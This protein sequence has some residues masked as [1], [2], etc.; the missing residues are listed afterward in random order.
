M[1]LAE[2]PWTLT[3]PRSFAVTDDLMRDEGSQINDG[4]WQERLGAF[5]KDASVYRKVQQCSK[6]TWIR[7]SVSYFV[8]LHRLHVY[9]ERHPARCE[10]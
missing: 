9:S 8:Y 10:R 7:V 2:L 4:E 3:R 1:V 6:C 5:F